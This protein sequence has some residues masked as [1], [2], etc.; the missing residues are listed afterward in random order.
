MQSIM[1]W[2]N[3]DNV[4]SKQT[5]KE[6]TE[7]LTSSIKSPDKNTVAIAEQYGVALEGRIKEILEQITT[8]SSTQQETIDKL[9]AE[10]KL[11]EK[12][13]NSSIKEKNTR[14]SS[15]ESQLD[16]TRKENAESAELIKVLKQWM[17]NTQQLVANVK[18]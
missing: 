5:L 13:L 10:K 15:L 2:F 7:K 6:L 11:L 3:N 12:T 14:I 18:K 8:T 4:K 16:N 17:E 9:N 1:D